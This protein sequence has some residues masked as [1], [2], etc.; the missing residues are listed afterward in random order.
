M[1][2]SLLL[3]VLLSLL[4]VEIGDAMSADSPLCA[5]I[6]ST[7]LGTLFSTWNCAASECTANTNFVLQPTSGTCTSNK[8]NSLSIVNINANA[9]MTGTI[10]A[11]FG[12]TAAAL[13]HIDLNTNKLFGSIPTNIASLNTGLTYL[14]LSSN[15]LTGTVPSQLCVSS[16]NTLKISS[17]LFTCYQDCLSTVPNKVYGSLGICGCK[18]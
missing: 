6:T 10:P 3:L 17:N 4:S 5:I 13:S 14:D 12:N 2:I 7:N 1:H 11:V 8:L 16:L 15:K 18:F 9:G